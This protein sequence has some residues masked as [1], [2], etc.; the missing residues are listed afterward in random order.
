[1]KVE[2]R[3]ASKSEHLGTWLSLIEMGMTMGGTGLLRAV[4]PCGLGAVCTC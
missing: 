1:M 3:V 2:A 4:C